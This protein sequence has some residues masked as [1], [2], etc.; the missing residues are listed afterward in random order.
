[1]HTSDCSHCLKL[2]R[3]FLSELNSF[4]C[5]VPGY[6]L[7]LLKGHLEIS[8]LFS[9]LFPFKFQ[10]LFKPVSSTRG[11][12]AALRSWPTLLLGGCSGDGSWPSLFADSL[13]CT[14][15][16]DSTKGSGHSMYTLVQISSSVACC[17]FNGETGKCRMDFENGKCSVSREGGE[18]PGEW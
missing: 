14:E 7:Q 10:C 4:H 9:H 8:K 17:C 13:G 12:S 6:F 18:R 11:L 1:M 3:Y 16:H 2:L 5:A 15:L